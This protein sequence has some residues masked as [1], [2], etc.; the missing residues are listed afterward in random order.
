MLYTDL[1]DNSL[2]YSKDIDLL[3]R[4]LLTRYEWSS[5]MFKKQKPEQGREVLGLFP[6][7]YNFF[8]SKNSLKKEPHVSLFC[9]GEHTITLM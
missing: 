2:S 3:T 6:S 7:S 8:F 1:T 5:S 4:T 9:V